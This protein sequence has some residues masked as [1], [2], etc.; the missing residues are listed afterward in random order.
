[1]ETQDKRG[2]FY[3]VPAR[4]LG[5]RLLFPLFEAIAAMAGG[6]SAAHELSLLL[7]DIRK[8]DKSIDADIEAAMSAMKDSSK[9][10]ERLQTK[11]E[12]DAAKLK[13]LQREIEQ[14][15]QAKA[16][17]SDALRPLLAIYEADS[18]P[19]RRRDFWVG[20]TLQAVLGLTLIVVGVLFAEPIKN[21]W[22]S[23]TR[24]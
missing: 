14:N 19:R 13:R 4:T 22:E 16:V 17:T 1:M 8:N 3:R 24:Q 2:D 5:E 20:L 6:S 18:R 23:L 11:L 12:D 21:I 15:E 9:L 7:G 10:I